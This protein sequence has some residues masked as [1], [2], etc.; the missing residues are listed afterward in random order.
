M[1]NVNN[2]FLCRLLP[3]FWASR[4]QCRC[5]KHTLDLPILVQHTQVQHTQVQHIQALHTQVQ[6]ILGQHTPVPPFQ[7]CQWALASGQPSLTLL[8][9]MLVLA[10]W[11]EPIQDLLMSVLV[12]WEAPIQD[13]P[14]S[15]LAR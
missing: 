1:E 5:L 14:M 4:L 8:Q 10:K 12:N 6:H 11:E 13:Q 3:P 7:V 9:P 2:P 15:G